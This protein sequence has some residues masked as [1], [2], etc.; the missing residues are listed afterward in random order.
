MPQGPHSESHR[1]PLKN[2]LSKKLSLQE[3]REREYKYTGT[4]NGGAAPATSAFSSVT[5]LFFTLC[6][7]AALL[8]VRARLVCCPRCAGVG[9]AQTRLPDAS[10]STLH[11]GGVCAASS[12]CKCASMLERLRA[13]RTRVVWSVERADKSRRRVRR[14]VRSH[15]RQLPNIK[16]FCCFC[17]GCTLDFSLLFLCR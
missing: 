8:G 3:K 10:V 7:H 6:T 16:S 2:F 13:P 14:E 5:E 15:P 9:G 11:L 4:H 1:S 17:P 12:P